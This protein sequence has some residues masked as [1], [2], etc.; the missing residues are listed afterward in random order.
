MLTC[1]TPQAPA[2]SNGAVDTA[3]Q[4]IVELTNILAGIVAEIRDLLGVPQYRDGSDVGD[5]TSGM[6]FRS[7][8]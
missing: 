7:S 6:Y 1:F 2:I 3:V 4:K 8:K 5:R